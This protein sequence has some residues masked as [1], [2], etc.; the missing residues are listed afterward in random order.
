MPLGPIA[1]CDTTLCLA[2]QW[3]WQWTRVTYSHLRIIKI[4]F[5]V[6]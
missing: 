6:C 5:Y 1:W 4:V 2:V 3:H